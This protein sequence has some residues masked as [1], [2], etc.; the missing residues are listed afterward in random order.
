MLSQSPAPLINLYL[1]P[2]GFAADDGFLK[3]ELQFVN[4]VSDRRLSDVQVQ[5][6]YEPVGNGSARYRYLFF[7][8][9]RFEGQNDTVTWHLNAAELNGIFREKSLRALKRGL[10][11]YLM[12]TSW[13][14]SLEYYFSPSVN[15]QQVRDGWNLWT[16]NVNSQAWISGRRIR[17]NQPSAYSDH[18]RELV[19]RENLNIWQITPDYRL[20]T[21]LSYQA[22]N[23]IKRVS[24][25]IAPDVDTVIRF[26]SRQQSMTANIYGVRSIGAHWAVGT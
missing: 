12:Q 23:G 15:N 4:H 24:Y 2:A 13:A 8:Y 16:F 5:A 17:Q 14:D 3:Q 6:V 11:P 10:L 22:L 19:F 21:E 26:D 9:G 20:G 1:D 18:L 7:G 25:T